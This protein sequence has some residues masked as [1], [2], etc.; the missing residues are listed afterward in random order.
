MKLLYLALC[1]SLCLCGCKKKAAES[2][3]TGDASAPTADAAKP[4]ASA[5]APAPGAVASAPNNPGLKVP[6]PGPP[7]KVNGVT[8]NVQEAE[9]ALATASWNAN[10]ALGNLRTD[11]R[12]E[13]YRAALGHLQTAAADPSLN[14]SQKAALQK[15]M[16]E[17]SQAAANAPR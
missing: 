17:V 2:A 7:V 9:K 10:V 6:P 11:L 3:S 1:L 8:I 14:E 4:E 15:V 13:D 5:P 12:Y 16:G